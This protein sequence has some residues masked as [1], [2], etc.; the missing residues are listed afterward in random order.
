M[1]KQQ[2]ELVKLSGQMKEAANLVGVGIK[3]Q[4]MKEYSKAKTAMLQG[5]ERIKKVLIKD[6]ST[7]KELV[8]EYVRIIKFYSKFK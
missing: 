1:K 4:E 5:I 2:T 3:L 6:N 8:F 7:D